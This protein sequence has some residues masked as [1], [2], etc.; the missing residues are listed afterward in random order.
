MTGH[1]HELHPDAVVFEDAAAIVQTRCRNGPFIARGYEDEIITGECDHGD[2]HRLEATTVVAPDG[3]RF[4]DFDPHDPSEP[5]PD[6]V[7]AALDAVE[8]AESPSRRDIE[9][10]IEIPSVITAEADG[11]TVEYRR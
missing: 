8:T 7:V 2:T 6:A 5:L 1:A 10:A 4:S 9:E 11:Y 3:E